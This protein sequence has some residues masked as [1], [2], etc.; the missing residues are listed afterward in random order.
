MTRSLGVLS[1][2]MVA[3]IT[4]VS[5]L[6]LG[7]SSLATHRFK[8]TMVC[9][10]S[11]KLQMERWRQI[12]TGL[13]GSG[14]GTGRESSEILFAPAN[15]LSRVYSALAGA[16]S[17]LAAK[18]S[19]YFYQPLQPSLS[20]VSA[21]PGA[22]QR[23]A[24]ITHP[25]ITHRPLLHSDGGWLSRGHFSRGHFSRGQLAALL[26]AVSSFLHWPPYAE[27]AYPAWVPSIE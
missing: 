27:A 21:A 8:D 6:L 7:Q 24:S 17:R 3:E 5:F 25:T 19:I 23:A 16:Y 14:G 4:A 20:N 9:L 12:V 13:I 10:S 1:E 15:T 11:A 22:A 18:S 2:C 26:D